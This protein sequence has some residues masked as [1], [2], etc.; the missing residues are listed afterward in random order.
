MTVENVRQDQGRGTIAWH[1]L[2]SRSIT[3]PSADGGRE[4]VREAMHVPTMTVS[5]SPRAYWAI[6]DC[7]DG[8]NK[9]LGGGVRSGRVEN[10]IL[11]DLSG[12]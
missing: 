4:K 10:I 11:V 2:E 5:T 1:M 9:P 7:A 8:G 6:G 3:S 12:G